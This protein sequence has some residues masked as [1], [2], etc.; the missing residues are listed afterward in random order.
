MVAAKLANLSLGANQHAGGGSANLPTLAVSQNDAA[1][2]L[3]VSGRSIRDAKKVREKAVP[4]I[5]QR[6]TLANL[7]DGVRPDKSA[8]DLGSACSRR[9]PLRGY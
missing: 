1:E 9:A 2:K 3:R 4:G 7:P 5:I 6:A 8:V